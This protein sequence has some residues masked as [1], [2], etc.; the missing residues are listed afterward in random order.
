MKQLDC[1]MEVKNISS[2]RQAK[3]VTL[4]ADV[5]FKGSKPERMYFETDVKNKSLIASDYSPFLAAV[6]LPCMKTGED[7]YIDGPVSKKLLQNT[8]KIMSVVESWNIG[9]KRV[10]INCHS[11]LDPE[12]IE[13]LKQVHDDK[14]YAHDNK[15]K[16][17]GVFFSAGVDSFYTYLKNKKTITDLI[18]VHG[19]DIPLTNNSLFKKMKNI[20]T[21]IAIEEKVN[22]ITVTTNIAEIVEKKLVWD[23]AHGGALAAV[24]LFLGSGLKT[25]FISGAVRSDMLFPY[26]TH[27]ALDKYWSTENTSIEHVGT[28]YNRLEKIMNKVSKSPLALRYLHVCTQNIKGEYNCSKC[29]KCLITML[30]LSCARVLDRQSAFDKKIDLEAVKNMYYDYALLYNL[31]GE[32]NLL[33]LKRQNI[34]PELQNAIQSSLEKSKKPNIIKKLTK[35]ISS[36][37]Q[38]H[39]DR[40]IYRAIFAM[41]KNQDRNILFKFL[42]KRGVFK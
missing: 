35:M 33:E 24:A 12:S 41:N 30:G 6:L 14:K 20:N 17:A 21:R 28:E 9:L 5:A 40:R 22:L 3:V 38:K 11:G 2:I 36:F 27:P 29:Y 37:D 32:A 8:K 42:L 19:F 31:Q 7:I 13:I 10:K 18:F 39:N 1:C 26:G 34:Y 16:R 4:S 23:F 25:A 15:S